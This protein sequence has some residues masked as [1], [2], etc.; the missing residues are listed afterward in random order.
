MIKIDDNG[1]FVGTE[2]FENDQSYV[3]HACKDPCHKRTVGYKKNLDKNHPNYLTFRKNE[4]NLYLNLVDADDPKY[5]A[6]LVID[7][8]I[9]FIGHVV[10][11]KKENVLI[12]C[13]KG[14]SRSAGLGLIWLIRQ[15][16]I[17]ADTFEELEEKYRVIYPPY[18]PQNG[19][20]MKIKEEWEA[21]QG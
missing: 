20:K 3:L 11:V 5:F 12:H 16:K 17:H 14:W 4:H 19:M 6:D 8:A 7:E 15:D 21:F 1:V 18:K 2:C 10:Y 9:D 13:N